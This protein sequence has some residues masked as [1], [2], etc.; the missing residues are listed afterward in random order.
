MHLVR[1]IMCVWKFSKQLKDWKQFPKKSFG[2]WKV[3]L[4]G[5]ISTALSFQHA[6][7]ITNI[8]CM[9]FIQASIKNK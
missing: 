8:Y 2:I 1:F 6:V 3:F 7:Q 4:N 9:L 5:N